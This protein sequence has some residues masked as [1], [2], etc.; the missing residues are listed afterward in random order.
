M[1]DNNNN[2]IDDSQE[3]GSNIADISQVS[4][5]LTNILPGFTSALTPPVREV[6][7]YIDSPTIRKEA[8]AIAVSSAKDQA[9]GGTRKPKMYYSGAALVDAAGLIARLPYQT[10][11]ASDAST[12]LKLMSG[13]E[14]LRVLGELKRTGWY[15][16]REISDLA[17]SQ[18]GFGDSDIKAFNDFLG[19]AVN[20][21][22]RTWDVVLPTLGNYSSV[23]GGGG[24]SFRVT[25]KEDLGAYLSA[26]SL[27]F[28]GRKMT[29][30]EV[31]EAVRNI[32]N[33]ERTQY[34]AGLN[35]SSPAVLAEQQAMDASPEEAG[36]Y[37]AGN[38][39]MRM[40]QLFG[41][42]KA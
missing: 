32:N 7:G 6:Y 34:A 33:R 28:L 38:A 10:D 26:A 22:G 3:S 16:G 20:P 27:K 30:A 15:Q 42:G 14:R 9:Y 17:L 23:G 2:G 37:S 41:Q 4:G 18:V 21:S 29:K 11:D 40:Y 31:L 25:S 12:Q 8:G 36:A 24:S 1:A 5:G 39:I 19:Q 13:N 35:V